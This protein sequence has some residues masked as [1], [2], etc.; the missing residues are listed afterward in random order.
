[1]SQQ[2]KKEY[3]YPSNGEPSYYTYTICLY[4]SKNKGDVIYHP[5][6]VDCC[7]VGVQRPSKNPTEV[8][9]CLLPQE[10]VVEL[11]DFDGFEPPVIKCCRFHK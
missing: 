2:R 1:M 10:D 8:Y 6:I 7:Q 5:Y 3:G 11:V 4:Q 9:R